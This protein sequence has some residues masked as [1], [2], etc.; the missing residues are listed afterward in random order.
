[1]K[2]LIDLTGGIGVER[3]DLTG[4]ARSR[5]CEPGPEAVSIALFISARTVVKTWRERKAEMKD[6][7]IRHGNRWHRHCTPAVSC[8][9]PTTLFHA[10]TLYYACPAACHRVSNVIRGWAW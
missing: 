2:S 10:C 8:L 3:R 1:V 6:I 9:S 5:R 4:E 7:T